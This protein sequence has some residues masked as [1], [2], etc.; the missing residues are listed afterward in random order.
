MGDPKI[1]FTKIKGRHSIKTGFEFQFIDTAV[2][3]FHPQYGTENYTGSFSDPSYFTNPSALNS[4]TS[5]QKQ[6]Y[7]MADFIFGADNHYELDNNPV[8]HLRQRMYFTYVQDD[9]KVNDKLTLNLGLRYE[10]ATPQYERD[11]RLS[12]FLPSADALIYAGSGSLYQRALVHP[13]WHNF[14]PRLGLAYQVAPKTV[15][16]QR[17]W[18]QLRAVQPSRRRKPA[19]VQRAEHRRCV[20]RPGAHAGNLRLGS[21]ARRL[22]LPHHAA[23]LPGELRVALFL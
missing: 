11:N 14:A 17:L 16:S 20:H 10:F 3:D 8:A 2:N 18:H 12:N 23:G 22:V 19:G 4:L 13:D 21:T 1:V 6:V 7:S 9:W 5:V 15:D